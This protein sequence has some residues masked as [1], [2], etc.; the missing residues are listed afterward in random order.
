MKFSIAER[1]AERKADAKRV[2][3]EGNIPAVLYSKG[4]SPHHIALKKEE[5]QAVLRNLKPGMLSTM[6]FELHNGKT[7]QKA[8]IKEVQYQPAT[9]EVEHI[10]FLELREDV[11]VTVKV[12]ILVVG[13]AECV[14]VKLGGM[15]HQIIR[16]LQVVCLPKDIPHELT[17]DVTEM[18]VADSKTLAD[19]KI[20]AH[21][22]PLAK[23]TE[24]LVTI[25]KKVVA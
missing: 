21:V 14:G 7:T 5:F 22:R 4:R 13:A 3:R 6:V 10:D 17:I 25:A 11:P 20:P 18:N 24:V 1:K 8:L 9:Y 23:L 16:S 12:P 15:M 2:R 19:L